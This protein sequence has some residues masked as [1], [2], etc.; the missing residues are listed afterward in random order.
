MEFSKQLRKRKTINKGIFFCNLITK[1][2]NS[3]NQSLS[4]LKHCVAANLRY[5]N[6]LNRTKLGLYAILTSRSKSPEIP[7]LS[8]G[9]VLMFLV[10]KEHTR[11]LSGIYTCL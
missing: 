8:K 3:G 6:Q 2:N 1:C 7:L 4:T 11:G 9:L 5:S 10:S